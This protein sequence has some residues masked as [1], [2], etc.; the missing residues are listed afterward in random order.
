MGNFCCHFKNYKQNKNLKKNKSIYYKLIL[1]SKIDNYYVSNK[2][3]NK[4]WIL[5]KQNNKYLGKLVKRNYKSMYE[6]EAL[7]KNKSNRLPILD[8]LLN[9]DY[10]S[11]IIYKYIKGFDLYD[12]FVSEIPILEKSVYPLFYQMVN[13]INEC[14]NL[15]YLHLDIKLENFIATPESIFNSNN[16]QYKLTL[17]DLGHCLPNVANKI[18]I[19]KMRG[20]KGY[21]APEILYKFVTGKSD[22][23]SL[24]CTIYVLLTGSFPFSKNNIKFI[25]QAS[26]EKYIEHKIH[27]IKHISKNLKNIM[28]QMFR[29]E[30]NDRISILNLQNHSYF[31]SLC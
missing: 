1:G 27:N 20:T 5:N 16:I 12:T 7:K 22:V 21:F 24:G 25:K 2:I 3:Y 15:G 19:S 14:H 30:Y 18:L 28:I 26:D 29:Y 13:C 11:F 10:C 4:V 23:W 8:K 6:I 31:K 9:Y 17:V